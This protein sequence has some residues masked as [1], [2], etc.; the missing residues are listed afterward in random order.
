MTMSSP[1]PV[2]AFT[3]VMPIV[4]SGTG[5]AR[6]VWGLAGVA[7]RLAAEAG[8][9]IDLRQIVNEDLSQTLSRIISNFSMLHEK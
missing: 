7:E 8:E 9:A 1:S 6:T 3:G 5:V 4:S 2:V